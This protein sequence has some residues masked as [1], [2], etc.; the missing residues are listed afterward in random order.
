MRDGDLG[1]AQMSWVGDQRG[2]NLEDGGA[3]PMASAVANEKGLKGARVGIEFHCYALNV[4]YYLGLADRLGGKTEL[5]DS[6]GILGRLRAAKSPA[7]LVFVREAHAHNLAG[8]EAAIASA[9]PG[10]TEIEW[11]AA[12]EHAVR[13]YGSDY[14]AMPTWIW[15]GERT[16]IGHATPTDR[17]LCKDEPAMFSFAGVSRRHHVSTYHTVHFGTPPPRLR[18]LFSL[19][20]GALAAEVERTR[21][22]E[23]IAAAAQAA[24]TV[25]DKAGLRQHMNVRWG[26]GVGLG[27]PPS[28]LE[29]VQISEDS[30]E[31]F[32]PG[33]MFCLHVG[34]AMP[35]EGHGVIVGGDYLL[36][37]TGC[38]ALDTTGGSPH[39]RELTIL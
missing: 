6:T 1:T 19:A 12:I 7:E 15:S 30:E 13:R 8:V 4:G 33:M 26:Y 38:E 24:A 32:S 23:P 20:Q 31:F 9:R 34:F 18:E 39:S 22:G 25:V 16:A 11:A 29:P 27:Y 14:S 10:I 35:A 3:A 36:N 17:V 37:D 21:P 5:V 28:W 2:Y